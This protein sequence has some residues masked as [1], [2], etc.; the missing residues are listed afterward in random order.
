M[1]TLLIAACGVQVLIQYVDTLTLEYKQRTQG[2]WRYNA[3]LL[4]GITSLRYES[5]VHD[6]TFNTCFCL[7]SSTSR[8]GARAERRQ[9]RRV[10]EV[11][12]QHHLS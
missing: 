9:S 3:H 12:R 1:P 5:V 2:N 6:L 8:S 10:V 4:L 11:H 7:F